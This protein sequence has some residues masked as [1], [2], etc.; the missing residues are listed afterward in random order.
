MKGFHISVLDCTDAGE[1]QALALREG[2]AFF[3]VARGPVPREL[4][5]QAVAF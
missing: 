1:G 5:R 2:A 3:I 4:H